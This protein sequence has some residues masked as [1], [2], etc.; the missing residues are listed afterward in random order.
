[1]PRGGTSGGWH[2]KG[3]EEA[4]GVIFI[5]YRRRRKGVGGFGRAAGSFFFFFLCFT[6]R[7]FYVLSNFFVVF[8]TH[9]VKCETLSICHILEVNA[10]SSTI[11]YIHSLL[12]PTVTLI[13]VTHCSRECLESSY[14]MEAKVCKFPAT[15]CLQVLQR[16]NRSPGNGLCHGTDCTVLFV[17]YR[18]CLKSS[19]RPSTAGSNYTRVRSPGTDVWCQDTCPDRSTECWHMAG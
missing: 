14:L 6:P 18:S 8:L 16:S 15:N 3:E 1:M 11:S 17:Q 4:S 7:E 10:G 19:S 5:E 9:L 12:V 13:V 2:I